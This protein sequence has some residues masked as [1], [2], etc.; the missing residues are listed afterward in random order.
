M[1]ASGIP[2]EHVR[3]EPSGFGSVATGEQ[4]FD[5]K[6]ACFRLQRRASRKRAVVR[7]Q[8]TERAIGITSLERCFRDIE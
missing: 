8:R 5:A 1:R 7:L 6:H 4:R 3:R 2:R